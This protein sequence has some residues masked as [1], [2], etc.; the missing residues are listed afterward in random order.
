MSRSVEIIHQ[1]RKEAA[2]AAKKE[3]EER[4]RQEAQHEAEWRRRESEAAQ[5]EKQERQERIRINTQIER[6]SGVLKE[7]HDIKDSELRGIK[8]AVIFDMDEGRIQLVWGKKFKVEDNKVVDIQDKS[9][10]YRDYSYVEVRLR[11]DH[12]IVVVRGGRYGT[13]KT[14]TIEKLEWGTDTNAIPRAL[15]DAFLDP[16]RSF[17][18]SES[19]SSTPDREKCCS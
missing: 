5:R 4:R 15:A 13:G 18:S 6:D 14:E 19:R 8:S 3:A 16:S 17:D 7:L 12:A 9:G 1:K 11:S 10:I 2:E